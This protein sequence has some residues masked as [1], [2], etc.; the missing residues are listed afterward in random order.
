MHGDGEKWR[1]SF[2]KV[3][4]N[5]LHGVTGKVYL[6][7]AFGLPRRSDDPKVMAW[8]KEIEAGYIKHFEKLMRELAISKGK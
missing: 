2:Q 5:E 6:L 8:M 3:I 1:E 7:E 4:R